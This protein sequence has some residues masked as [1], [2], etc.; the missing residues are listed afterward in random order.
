MTRTVTVLDSD[1]MVIRNKSS[2]DLDIHDMMCI[3]VE[4]SVLYDNSISIDSCTTKNPP[5]QSEDYGFTK[6]VIVD[7]ESYA[8]YLAIM[9]Y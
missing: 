4:Y 6:D 7:N 9:E 1:R 8:R 3:I 2:L 5:I